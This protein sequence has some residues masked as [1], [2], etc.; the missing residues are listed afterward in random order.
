MEC[1]NMVIFCKDPKSCAEW[2]EQEVF[3]KRI[4]DTMDQELL[5]V[6]R[7]QMINKVEI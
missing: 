5:Q 7:E 1:Q 4:W 2:D 6:N 3:E